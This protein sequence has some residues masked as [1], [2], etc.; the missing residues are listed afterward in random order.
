MLI[1]VKVGVPKSEKSFEGSG[2]QKETWK[3]K[4]VR[5]QSPYLINVACSSNCICVD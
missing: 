5:K 2:M 3:V 4:M 1:L